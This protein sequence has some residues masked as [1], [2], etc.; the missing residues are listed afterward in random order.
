MVVKD[1][2]N[3]ILSLGRSQKFISCF[4]FGPMQEEDPMQQEVN[5][6]YH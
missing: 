2:D 4:G 5:S 6:T 3:A 1:R